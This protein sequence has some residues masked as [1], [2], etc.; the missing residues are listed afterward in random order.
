MDVN[1]SFPGMRGPELPTN[2]QIEPLFLEN[3]PEAWTEDADVTWYL[4]DSEC[5]HLSIVANPQYGIWL[6]H[7]HNRPDGSEE[8]Y[9][10]LGNIE[11]LDTYVEAVED[12]LTLEGFFLPPEQAWLAVQD[13]INSPGVRSERINW[14][15][16][17]QVPRGKY[18]LVSSD[19]L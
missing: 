11:K 14:M 19:C 4:Q 10:S 16:E 3:F 13:F 8:N 15:H 7:R 6:W 18:W 9:I 5:Y 1:A 2:E 12:S 17:D